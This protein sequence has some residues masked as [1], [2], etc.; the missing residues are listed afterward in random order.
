MKQKFREQLIGEALAAREQAYA[1]YS[2]FAVGAA[3]L[4][5]DG[6]VWRG[7]NVENAAFGA[8]CC[9]ER[10]ALWKAVSEGRR[11]FTAICVVGGPMG[12][13]TLPCCPPCGICRQAL[14]EFVSPEDFELILAQDEAHYQEM[15]L[16]QLLPLSFGPEALP[17]S[18]Q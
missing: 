14:R 11:R 4:A 5:E 18:S 1:P 7:C 10:T 2:G 13:K 12:R 8:G 9:A 3:L 16:E 17:Q 6:S 15:K